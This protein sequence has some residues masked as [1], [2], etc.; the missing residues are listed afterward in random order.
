[1]TTEHPVL[2]AYFLGTFRVSIDGV[3]VDTS[4]RRRARQVLAY[5]LAHRRAPVPRDVLIDVFWPAAGLAAG[6]NNLHVALSSVRKALRAAHPAATVERRFDTYRV[7]DSVTIWTDVDQMSEIRAGRLR[8]ERRGDQDEA[9]RLQEAACQ[10]YGGDFLADEPYLDWAM[11]IREALRLEAIEIQSDLVD[12]Y[13][14]RGAHGPAAVLARR[15]VALDPCNETVHRQLM[16]CYV[17]GG[18]RHLALSQYHRLA[19]LL[20]TGLRIRPSAGTTAL[21][22]RLRRPEAGHRAA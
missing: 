4:S 22:E 10:L 16:T 6:R 3:P 14:E 8:A 21:F 1:V 7:G 19:E 18:H 2:A 13:L 12:R 20:W 15:L 9:L 17:A 5:L 11:P